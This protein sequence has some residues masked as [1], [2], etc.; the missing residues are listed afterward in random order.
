MEQFIKFFN[1]IFSASAVKSYSEVFHTDVE[2]QIRDLNRCWFSNHPV[3]SSAGCL[4]NLHPWRMGRQEGGREGRRDK[5]KGGRGREGGKEYQDLEVY[6]RW[7]SGPQICHCARCRHP[8]AC[9]RPGAP[10]SAPYTTATGDLH[11]CD[12]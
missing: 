7:T 10:S 8:R 1:F 9:C 11:H 12:R 6:R 2:K 4:E 5:E 3:L